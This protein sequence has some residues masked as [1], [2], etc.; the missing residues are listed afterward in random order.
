MP[1]KTDY[2]PIMLSL[3]SARLVWERETV[4]A[5]W[6][7]TW[8]SVWSVRRGPET[9]LK[10]CR[11]SVTRETDA[12]SKR[13]TNGEALRLCWDK[14]HMTSVWAAHKT[15]VGLGWAGVVGAFG[16]GM[17]AWKSHKRN[18]TASN[19]TMVRHQLYACLGAIPSAK[20]IQ[21]PLTS[22]KNLWKHILFR[23]NT[24]T[25]KP[26]F[27]EEFKNGSQNHEGIKT[28]LQTIKLILFNC[29]SNE[30]MMLFHEVHH[31]KCPTNIAAILM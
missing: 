5:T 9:N 16:G 28:L 3:E 24:I 22:T 27:D 14:S 30:F 6:F 18:Q 25:V 1:I 29:V 31:V 12:L 26:N 11:H 8:E 4:E 13:P 19:H 20:Q 15:W 17:D 21:W 7:G 2:S 23:M 10:W